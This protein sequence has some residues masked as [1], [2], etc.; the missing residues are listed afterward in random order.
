MFLPLIL[1]GMEVDPPEEQ[2]VAPEARPY[3]AGS[4]IYGADYA[5]AHP[6]FRKAL[7]KCK[8]SDEEARKA[9]GFKKT[10]ALIEYENTPPYK[11]FR[12]M[13][14]IKYESIP[15]I[16]KQTDNVNKRC[17]NARNVNVEHIHSFVQEVREFGFMS[18]DTEGS[19]RAQLLQLG[20]YRGTVFY[21]SPTFD[22]AD[23]ENSDYDW[24]SFH[25]HLRGLLADEYIIK[26]QSAPF[27]DKQLLA[28]EGIVVNSCVDTRLLFK[29]S[30]EFKSDD[31]KTKLA[32]I[33]KRVLKQTWAKRPHDYVWVA[34]KLSASA[35]KHMCQD[36]RAP[37]YFLITL[38]SKLIPEAA[39][40]SPFLLQFLYM[41]L[42]IECDPAQFVKA[43]NVV[44]GDIEKNQHGPHD[45]KTVYWLLDTSPY[46]VPIEEHARHAE[47]LP[48]DG[49]A[50]LLNKGAEN[51]RLIE[52]VESLW[53]DQSASA[54]DFV[55]VTENP[56]GWCPYCGRMT[57]DKTISHDECSEKHK[58]CD[59]VMCPSFEGHSTIF[60]PT[61]HGVC[62][63]CGRRGHEPEIHERSQEDAF[64]LPQIEALTL[65]W[66]PLGKFT[67]VPFLEL[68]KRATEVTDRH[69]RYLPMNQKRNACQKYFKVL[70]IAYKAPK[71]LP[72]RRR[73]QEGE[74]KKAPQK[75][76]ASSVPSREIK[77]PKKTAAATATSQSASAGSQTSVE[78]QPGPSGLQKSRKSRSKGKAKVSPV[79]QTR[80][81]AETRHTLET[82]SVP[83]QESDRER[84]LR[85][86]MD[87]LRRENDILRRHAPTAVL[88]D[89]QSIRIRRRAQFI[90][91]FFGEIDHT[92]DEC[93]MDVLIN[94]D[95]TKNPQF[96]EPGSLD[97]PMTQETVPVTQ[98][99][100][101]M[102]QATVTE[103]TGEA[104]TEG[105]EYVPQGSGMDT[106]L[107]YEPSQ[108]GEDTNPPASEHS[109]A[110]TTR[111]SLSPPSGQK[112]VSIR[113]EYSD[114]SDEGDSDNP[115]G[116]PPISP[117][118]SPRRYQ[119]STRTSPHTSDAGMSPTAER[120]AGEEAQS[121]IESLALS[122]S[123][124]PASE[125]ASTEARH[126]R[127]RKRE[128][129]PPPKD[130]P[131]P[132]PKRK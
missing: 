62:S 33:V 102:A 52:A 100:S 109:G 25:S 120:D 1:S 121:G 46:Y 24:T 124:P 10:L 16:L 116:G 122:S 125:P 47:L 56:K 17:Y 14:V 131:K 42:D 89:S 132:P 84:A 111:P 21:Y 96:Y 15:A 123:E 103:P 95:V 129:T 77:I 66:C 90:R 85:I 78:S 93:D 127:S 35:K 113:I 64:S 126:L 75:R 11:Q 80:Q 65:N 53:A 63:T 104:S 88:G 105:E 94:I 8:L 91:R 69:W 112:D 92:L 32:V 74:E 30:D 57:K 39:N 110:E 49:K 43:N 23:P 82:F 50:F 68:S 99:R 28:R 36:V 38:V 44:A 22:E 73:S 72:R 34:S 128:D 108:I 79:L 29:Y 7:P 12:K 118:S 98:L 58:S 114:S 61:L 4:E 26:L 71:C 5:N 48:T 37:L 106:S 2:S 67:S 115:L 59:Y 55:K 130:V 54:Y 86:E 60:C 18:F 45:I 119:F 87:I 13:P 31:P 6:R 76:R 20:S 3:S 9:T 70:G 51:A 107:P 83:G 81:V 19:P 40:L 101:L 117:L 41:H 97:I 27:Q